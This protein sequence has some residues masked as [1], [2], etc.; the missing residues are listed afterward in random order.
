MESVEILVCAKRL[1]ITLA[2]EAGCVVA[3]PKGATP[4]NLAQAI[5]DNK[6]QL[7]ALLA[8]RHPE[9]YDLREREEDQIERFARAD[10][11]ESL[12]EPGAPAYSIVESCR[13]D[14]VALRID[15]SGDLVVGKAGAKADEPTQPWPELLARIEAHLEAVA[16]LVEAGWKL[17]AGFPK[18]PAV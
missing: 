9:P 14:G 4:P 7:L 2:A 13:E 11:W 8:R 6:P 18:Q 10:G 17:K 5:R 3:R 16:W 1:G 15:E 12:P